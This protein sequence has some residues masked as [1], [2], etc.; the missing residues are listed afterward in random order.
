MLLFTVDGCCTISLDGE[1]VE[2]ELESTVAVSEDL[3]G[4]VKASG[5]FC[6]S[7]A[8]VGTR[9]VVPLGTDDGCRTLELLG[10]VVEEVRAE[11]GGL[12]V[13]IEELLRLVV[14][15]EACWAEEL[16]VT[17]R[18]GLVVTEDGCRTL[19]LVGKTVEDVEA[20]LDDVVAEE[21]FRVQLLLLL[22]LLKGVC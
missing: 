10:E 20:E 21:P 1:L 7:T 12:G 22:L 14:T 11:L 5:T 16:V 3:L 4:L 19:E 18:L 9:T 8:L 13:T 6:A 15:T 2:V 17:K